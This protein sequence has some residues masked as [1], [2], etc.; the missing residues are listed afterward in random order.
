MHTH[1]TL[2]VS[3]LDDTLLDNAGKL[4]LYTKKTLYTAIEKYKNVTFASARSYLSIQKIFEDI[5]LPLPI[6][7]LNGGIIR[8]L[9]SNIVIMNNHIDKLTAKTINSEIKQSSCS[10]YYTLASKNKTFW[11]LSDINKLEIIYF[12]GKANY[13]G[14]FKDKIK[15]SD[16][17]VLNMNVLGKEKV[18]MKLF[19]ILSD[20]NFPH[21]D[22]F[23]Y[24]HGNLETFK[25]LSIHHRNATKGEAIIQLLKLYPQFK[26]VTVF[27]DNNNDISMFTKNFTSCVVN[28]AAI[29]IKKHADQIIE[30]NYNDGVA[31][32]LNAELLA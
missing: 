1:Q 11:L 9:H 2:Y 3:D 10:Y 21:I 6:I 4:S 8:N 17:S 22:I 5:K 18:I 16:Y 19:Y 29:S 31:K 27:G 23:T 25:W 28:N 20:Y 15:I 24:A 13:Q 30:E 12:L 7:E 26:S 32:Y 14:C